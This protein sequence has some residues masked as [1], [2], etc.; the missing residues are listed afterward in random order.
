MYQERLHE[1]TT[2]TKHTGTEIN[3]PE[4]P[5]LVF[6]WWQI[7]FK[8]KFSPS[9]QQAVQGTILMSEWYK[10]ENKSASEMSLPLSEFI[11]CTLN[12]C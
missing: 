12:S 6:V 2:G 3:D 7:S 4:A 11:G 9:L 10:W 1:K 8:F 5:D